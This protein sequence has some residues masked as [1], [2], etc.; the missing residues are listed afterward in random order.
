MS[1]ADNP[2][3]LDRT[4]IVSSHFFTLCTTEDGFTKVL[5]H[6]QIPKG[7]RPPFVNNWHS[8]AT[9]HYFENRGERTKS[10]VVCVANFEKKSPPQIAGL[11]A[12][13][14][15]HIWQQIKDDYGERNPSPE[16]EAYSI[17]SITQQLLT[18][19]YRQT[20]E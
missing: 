16:F 9:A 17:Q 15:T 19:F 11:L 18:E 3:W 12:H 5:K 4:L 2:K 6:L 7:Q 14:A 1:K 20:K 13:E 10:V 8:D